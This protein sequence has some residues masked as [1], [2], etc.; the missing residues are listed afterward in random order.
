MHMR[1]KDRFIEA[2]C[3]ARGDRRQMAA[4]IDRRYNP[5]TRANS[6]RAAVAYIAARLVEALGVT[7]VVAVGERN[8][9]G[10]AAV[11]RVRAVGHA[12][13]SVVK[14][15][16]VALTVTI[17][18]RRLIKRLRLVGCDRPLARGRVAAVLPGTIVRIDDVGQL[19]VADAAGEKN[20][21]QEEQ[22]F[23][24]APRE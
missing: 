10:R 5:I 3:G 21:K 11:V 17:A 20:R 13:T 2:N 14:S 7:F 24:H 15:C 16:V 6:E 4:V 12:T 9:V 22:E 8:I 19:F 23:F 1:N 18:I